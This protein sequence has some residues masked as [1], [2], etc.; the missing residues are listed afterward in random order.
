MNLATAAQALG[1][2]PVGWAA[3]WAARR[4]AGT[5]APTYAAMIAIEAGAALSA[6]LLAPAA[7]VPVLLLAG[8][9]LGLLAMVDLLSL[10]LPDLLTLPLGVA[11][12]VFGPGLVGTPLV[13]HVIGGAA[14]YAVLSLV[15]WAYARVRGRDGMGLGDAKLLAAGGAWLGW[16]ALPNVVVLACAGGIAWAA[17]RMLRRGRA[18]LAEPIAFGLPLCAAIWASLLLAVAGAGA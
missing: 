13:E 18:G 17:L 11:G 3:T 7:E 15:S 5:A 10:R 12:L 4:L 1:C 9:T 2:V 6:A 14:G 16:T 8:W